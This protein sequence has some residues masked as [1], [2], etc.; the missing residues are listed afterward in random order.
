NMG[1]RM[2]NLAKARTAISMQCGHIVNKSSVYETAAWGRED[3]PPFL[4]QVMVVET[5]LQPGELLQAIL[6][7]ER[8]LGRTREKK[9]GPRLIDI[10]ILFYND[11]VISEKGLVV[12]HPQM[13][14]RRFVLEPLA[15]LSPD[16]WH[17]VLQKKI[18]ELLA[19]CT[20]PLS[21]NKIT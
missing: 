5:E 1:E 11:E 19:E 2:E 4:N 8:S 14:Y 6:I 9:Y 12:P 13:Q 17:P 7:I 15:Q 20:D 21:V 10:D 16:K 3:Q 18:S